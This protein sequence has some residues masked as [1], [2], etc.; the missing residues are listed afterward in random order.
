MT[1]KPPSRKVIRRRPSLAADNFNVI[2]KNILETLQSGV[3]N[4]PPSHRALARFLLTHFHEAVFLT[5][6]QLAKRT[7]TSESTV[8]RLT[9]ALGYQGFPEFREALQALL[10][11]KL[12]PAER[13][14]QTGGMPKEIEAILHQTAVRALA[15]LRE[16]R[17]LFSF[18]LLEAAAKVLTAARI[19]YIVGLRASA[20]TAYLLG[21]YLGQIQPIVRVETEGGPVLFEHLASMSKEDALLAISYPRYTRWTI[22]SLRFARERGA[23]TIAI[24][25]SQV[26]PAAQLAEIALV[27]R[28]DSI[29]FANSYVAPMLVVDA[30]VA[31]TLGLNP[32]ESLTRLDAIEQAFKGHDFFYGENNPK[33]PLGNTTPDQTIEEEKS[34]CKIGTS[35]RI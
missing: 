25:D 34:G 5:A 4:H 15:N 11:Q 26:S 6:A 19:K 9:K 30:L 22:E 13:M 17:K 20:A 14:Q 2:R 27:A 18:G 28:A 35:I 21:H 1:A 16:T 10:R 29:T 8:I 33:R 31:V 3:H 12:A 23:A 7:R 32:E 24:T